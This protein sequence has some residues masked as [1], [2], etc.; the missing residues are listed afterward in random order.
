MPGSS[1]VR[2]ST[3]RYIQL[4]GA[5]AF[6][7]APMP[8]PVAFE[9]KAAGDTEAL[10]PTSTLHNSNNGSDGGGGSGGEADDRPA[11]T[12]TDLRWLFPAV[13]GRHRQ[14][15]HH[16]VDPLRFNHVQGVVLEVSA[17]VTTMHALVRVQCV[18]VLTC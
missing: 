5:K 12:T 14:V 9:S 17:C 15:K 4:D 13:H 8:I 3:R 11:P 18:G 7:L 10:L 1:V 16:L 6:F 2:V